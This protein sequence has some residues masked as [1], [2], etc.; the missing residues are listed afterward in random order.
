[1]MTLVSYR[2]FQYTF[3]V[4]YHL[5]YILP[6]PSLTLSSSNSTRSK[7]SFCLEITLWLCPR[8]PLHYDYEEYPR[9]L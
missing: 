3:Q 4:R 8:C 2:I 7:Q 1:M 5:R 6:L 9:T